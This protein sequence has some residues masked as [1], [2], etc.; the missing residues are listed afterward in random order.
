M[1][2]LPAAPTAVILP[3]WIT[4]T[5]FGMSGEV[6]GCTVAPTIAVT[7][8]TGAVTRGPPATFTFPGNAF[9]VGGAA[10]GSAGGFAGGLADGGGV[11]PPFPCPCPPAPLP[12]K[13][14]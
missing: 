4:T 13:P 10:G 8:P 1:A 5:P 3:P 11:C 12:P 2:T 9:P 7:G 14:G 6:S